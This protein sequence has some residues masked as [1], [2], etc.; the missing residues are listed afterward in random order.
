MISPAFLARVE[1]ALPAD[2]EPGLDLKSLHE[3]VDL[4][5]PAHVG[6]AARALVMLGRATWQ[7]G[8]RLLAGVPI[9]LY[10]RAPARSVPSGVSNAAS[11]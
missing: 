3:R 2:D 6:N 7:P 1:R 8:D 5:T 4:E 10:R 11:L 9:R